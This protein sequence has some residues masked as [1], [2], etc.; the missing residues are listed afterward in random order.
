MHD[1]ESTYHIIYTEQ[2]STEQRSTNNFEV[3]RPCYYFLRILGIWQPPD[4]YLLWKLYN[5]FSFVLWFASLTVTVALSYIGGGTFKLGMMVNSLGTIMNLGCPFLFCRYFFRYGNFDEFL[6]HMIQSNET[7]I[8]QIKNKSAV[9]T[10]ISLLLWILGS[11]FFYVHWLPF[12]ERTYHYVIYGVTLFYTIGW[13]ACWLSVYGFVCHVHKDQIDIFIRRISNSYAYSTRTTVAEEACV[14]DLLRK[15]HEL[16]KWLSETQ[17]NFSKI[18]SFAVAYHIMDLFLFS[19]AYWSNDFGDYPIWQ[20]IG[21][22]VFDLS[23]ILMK[24]YPA[25]VVSQALHDV[26]AV[27]GSHCY[28]DINTGLIPKERFAFYQFIYLRE[29]DLGFSIL[30]VKVTSKVTV[31]IFVTIATATLTFLKYIVPYLANLF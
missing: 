26:V 10:L 15:F 21:G 18:I 19:F 29:Q 23:S 20:Y 30:G 2:R 3:P 9:Y 13:W 31:G 14:V 17:E 24:L 11:A 28:P 6:T 1:F 27:T 8:K 12:F 7:S 4:S 16:R 25:A 5:Y 22:V